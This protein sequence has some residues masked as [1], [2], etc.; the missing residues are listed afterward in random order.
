VKRLINTYRYSEI[1][2]PN[3]QSSAGAK[4]RQEKQPDVE[5][6]AAWDISGDVYGNPLV[7]GAMLRTWT[8]G[9]NFAKGW[10]TT[11]RCT[12]TVRHLLEHLQVYLLL[13][14]IDLVSAQL[15]PCMV[16][17]LH[18]PIVPLR[19]AVVRFKTRQYRPRCTPPSDYR[20]S[21]ICIAR[22]ST[23]ERWSCPRVHLATTPPQQLM[24]AMVTPHQTIFPCMAASETPLLHSPGVRT[25]SAISGSMP[26]NAQRR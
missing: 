22:P 12:G 1:S 8:L 15:V 9:D 4:S 6:S 20:R 25:C 3:F 2:C 10:N 24:S 14:C 17:P 18:N 7:G 13:S 23:L 5:N 19:R 26:H 11:P 21:Y 16:A